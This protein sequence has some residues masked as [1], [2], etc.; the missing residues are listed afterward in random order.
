[1]QEIREIKPTEWEAI[2][3]LS[4]ATPDLALVKD[5]L[6]AALGGPQPPAGT[7]ARPEAP[8]LRPGTVK[9]VLEAV[10]LG[11]LTR[12]E[13]RRYF[14]MPPA[15]PTSGW[16]TWRLGSQRGGGR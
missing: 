16:R 13:A 2:K 14:A 15:P 7:P 11:V 3:E 4:V 5:R 8:G 10:K 6:L 9:E 12:A 1:M